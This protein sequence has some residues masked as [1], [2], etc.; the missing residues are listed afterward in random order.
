MSHFS[1]EDRSVRQVCRE[2]GREGGRGGAPAE[3]NL[4]EGR[5]EQ[6]WWA[7]QRA[8]QER[9]PVRDVRDPPSATNGRRRTPRH[10]GSLGSPVIK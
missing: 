9:V 4:R 3:F 7:V 6:N 10:S 1:R 5:E 8:G 2:I